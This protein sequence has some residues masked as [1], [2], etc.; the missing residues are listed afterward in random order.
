MCEEPQTQDVQGGHIFVHTLRDV[1][2][3]KRIEEAERQAKESLIAA[4]HAKSQFIHAMSHEL[5]TPLNAVIGFSEMMSNE[6]AGPLGNSTYA[7]YIKMIHDGG[8]HLLSVVNDVLDVTRLESGDVKLDRDPIAL[9]RL[10]ESVRAHSESELA[11][12][13]KHLTV[14][15]PED[16]RALGR[17]QAL[18]ISCSI[19]CRTP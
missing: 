5:R 8:R 3:R 14:D 6:T 1:S 9:A 4:S 15:V 10:V 16:L 11:A 18:S 2:A 7:E 13:G 17:P 19:C 12:G